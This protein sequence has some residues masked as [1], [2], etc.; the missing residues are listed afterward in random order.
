M[1]IS[2]LPQAQIDIYQKYIQA[3]ASLSGLFSESNIPFL[4]YRVA[5]NIFCK[6]FAAENLS[7]ADISYDAKIDVIGIGLKTFISRQDTSREKIAEF[8]SHSNELQNL[9]TEKKM[10]QRLSALRNERIEFANRTYG[11]EKG[12][13][14]CLARQEN[15]INIF[16]TNYEPINI[17]RLKNIYRTKPSLFFEDDS[18]EYS[19]NFSKSTLYRKFYTP[20]NS[21][22]IDIKII[23]DPYELILKIFS[24]YTFVEQKKL[25]SVILP[26][27]STRNQNNEKVVP[28]KSGLNQWNASGRKRNI[29]EVYIPIPQKVHHLN[30]DFFPPR[31]KT[32]Y[33]ILPD[34]NKLF[35]KV[36]QEGNKALMTNPNKALS[37]WL[38]RKI[39]KLKLGEI[40]TYQNLKNLGV[41]SVKITKVDSD[42]FKIDFVQLGSYE[43]F[44]G[45][46]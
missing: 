11:I 24:E 42:N 3:I 16:E 22:N 19:F 43:K 29:G 14:H 21:F 26:L 15:K 5:E 10:A 46:F 41:D 25:A 40:L 13:Y 17:N 1:F 8:N 9:E 7:R 33:I 34:G 20:S 12:I 45:D 2:N 36:C 30:P 23:N 4:H 6:S 32:F 35:A 28:A 39:L 38:L 44:T 31:D 27:Y 18:N 37:E